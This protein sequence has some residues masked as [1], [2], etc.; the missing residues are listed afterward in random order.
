MLEWDLSNP[1]KTH[2]RVENCS[3]IADLGAVS[4]I[5]TLRHTSLPSSER[6]KISV[7][8]YIEEAPWLRAALRSA[9]S[10]DPM[11]QY[12]LGPDG[13]VDLV[14]ECSREPTEDEILM[15]S[16]ENFML[17]LTLQSK[18]ADG[19]SQNL[20]VELL[21]PNLKTLKWTPPVIQ[22][23]QVAIPELS[24]VEKQDRDEVDLFSIVVN[25][26]FTRLEFGGPPTSAIISGQLSCLV[27]D[28]VR[29]VSANL[30]LG[31]LVVRANAGVACELHSGD[32]VSVG[33]IVSINEVF[34]A[35]EG[36][37]FLRMQF[38]WTCEF[39]DETQHALSGTYH[40][41]L[42]LR[43]G[44]I[45]L[46]KYRDT[47]A[48]PN[49]VRSRTPFAERFPLEFSVP[50]SGGSVQFELGD[51]IEFEAVF[52]D[53]SWE[54]VAHA[55]IL[56]EGEKATLSDRDDFKLIQDIVVD[57][58]NGAKI[59]IPFHDT[60]LDETGETDR[61][62]LFV[63]FEARRLKARAGV[64]L[65]SDDDLFEHKYG[66]IA[67]D[68]VLRQRDPKY[69]ICLD[70]GASAVAAWFGRVERNLARELIPL[71]SFAY[72]LAGAHPEYDPNKKHWQ[73]VLIP[74]TIGLNPAR[75]LRSRRA[76]LSYGNLACVGTK[77]QAAEKRMSVFGRTYDV[78]IPV[79]RNFISD[80]DTT[81]SYLNLQT[82][83]IPDLKRMLM[84]AD[85]EFKYRIKQP[86]IERTA[87]GLQ[88]TR[89]INLSALTNDAFHELGSYIIPNSLFHAH[90]QVDGPVISEMGDERFDQWLESADNDVQVVV[91][92]PSGIAHHKRELYKSA[93]RSF[94]TGM[95]GAED[96]RAARE[97]KL[98]PEALSAAYFGISRSEL[99]YQGTRMFA[100]IDV[101]ASTVDASLIEVKMRHDSIESWKVFAHFGATIGGA[102]LDEA[103]L[104]TLVSNLRELF[105]GAEP[106]FEDLELDHRF[107]RD[108][109]LKTTLLPRIQQAKRDLS[110]ALMQKAGTDGA[111]NWAR[112]GKGSAF[113]V[114]L[115]EILR[116]ASPGQPLNARRTPV[117]GSDDLVHL[118]VETRSS[119]GQAVWMEISPDLLDADEPVNN[120]APSNPKTVARTLG[121]AV[122][123]MLIREARRLGLEDPQWVI[124]GR[125]SL[126]PSVFS[127]IG[128]TAQLL[129]QSV[130]AVPHRP[131]NADDMKNAT[132]YGAARLATSGLEITDGADHSYALVLHDEG[133][134]VVS[135]IEYLDTRSRSEGNKMVRFLPN[136]WLSRVLPG[137]DEVGT[138]NDITR[139]EIIRLFDVF[140]QKV[141]V[142]QSQVKP[143]GLAGGGDQNVEISWKRRNSEVEFTVGDIIV[144]QPRSR[145]AG[146]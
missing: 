24:R 131:F 1:K 2:L 75:H 93:A 119:G 50:I 56:P 113:T 54:V 44:E 95:T 134:G 11:L 12:D 118:C 115:D 76:P 33:C 67:V 126:W 36:A 84:N 110:D 144:R 80:D 34:D 17:S 120:L 140:G 97:P 46:L 132:V 39:S 116:S 68:I 58:S 48:V 19:K 78:S 45:L 108:E 52:L 57:P 100:C 3:V 104:A 106:V 112:E 26:P 136:R 71:G 102:N 142:D 42:Q 96:S 14:L 88:T 73:N 53:D 138:P 145:L 139:D 83:V 101:G 38:D 127:G 25:Q 29:K 20:K 63:R 98:I 59:R 32:E 43:Q 86:V 18:R 47:S 121:Y 82:I 62:Q 66:M 22:A 91:T 77:L 10:V 124:T 8:G 107:V 55:H 61:Y 4:D 123:A 6:L 72:S 109:A 92:H 90:D 122:P 99:R 125:A 128:N 146:T 94:A 60:T 49:M 9:D 70:Y 114:D 74:S 5:V 16:R 23:R 31:A 133:R 51:T 81:G 129:G 87:N 37:D 79:D 41:D 89:E 111:F 69:L 15:A 35:A 105:S 27:D 28:E 40:F 141:V 117:P 143:G 130:D 135:E 137:L 21:G 30:C 85:T 65:V 103:L 13:S 64:S 7:A